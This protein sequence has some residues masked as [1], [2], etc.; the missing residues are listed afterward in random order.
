M[1]K[2]PNKPGGALTLGK[3]VLIGGLSVVLLGV[4]V[5]QFSGKKHDAT[6]QSPSRLSPEEQSTAP[7][8]S[9]VAT[10]S[11]SNENRA[12]TPWPTFNVTEVVSSNP[13]M[14]PEVLVPRRETAQDLT[15]SSALGKAEATVRA[16]ESAELRE[17]RRQQAEFI[18]GLRAKGVD[19]ILRSPRGSVAR[20][21]ELS[22]RVGDIYEGL[23]VEEIGENGVVFAPTSIAE[24]QPE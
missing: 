8:S 18:A 19:M 1:V 10:A 21:G 13:F 11:A 3:A 4:I 16:F 24:G 6:L 2:R 20:V 5:A 17:M 7:T 12:E 23:R 15:S 9:S 22:L 14:L